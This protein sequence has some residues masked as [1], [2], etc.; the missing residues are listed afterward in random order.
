[1]KYLKVSLQQCLQE[2]LEIISNGLV[3]LAVIVEL[4]TAI[5]VHPELRLEEHSV[6][7][8]KQ[9]VAENLEVTVGNNT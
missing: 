2:I 3:Q 6:E 8:K 5:L 9:E 7:K 1:M 4:L